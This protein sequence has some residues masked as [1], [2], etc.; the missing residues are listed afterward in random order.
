[1]P[2]RVLPSPLYAE[3][4]PAWAAAGQAAPA[5]P[6]QL[7]ASAQALAAGLVLPSAPALEQLLTTPHELEPP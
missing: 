7:W 5:E 4:L 1:M 3:L 6:P 2:P